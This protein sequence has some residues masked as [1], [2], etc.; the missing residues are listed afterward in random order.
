MNA[1]ASTTESL[2]QEAAQLLSEEKVNVVIGYGRD[3]GAVF[4]APVFV[5]SADQVDRLVF[6]PLCF[7]NLAVYLHRDEVR[8]MG[9]AGVVVKG[10]DL[11]AVNVLLR[12]NVIERDQVVLIGVRCGGVGEPALHKCAICESRDPQGCDVVVGE[13]LEQPDVSGEPKYP[14]ADAVDAMSLEDRWAFWREKLDKC[15]RCYA[16]R[17]VCPLCYCKRCIVDKTV[18]RWVESSAH[19]RGNIAWNVARA[20]HLTGRCVGCGECQR[21]CPMDIPLGAI[22]QKMAKI[23]AEWF[24]FTSGLSAEEQAPFTTFAIDDSDEGIL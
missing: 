16:C 10:C 8:K 15:I 3:D 18:P 13:P 19:L 23:V 21:V 11:R 14:D 9:K 12:E 1:N 17:Q 6:D 24:E 20:F 22:N 2:R 5:R 4:S 7:G